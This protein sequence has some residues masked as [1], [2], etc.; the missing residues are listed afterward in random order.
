MNHY[1]RDICFLVAIVI[2]LGLGIYRVHQEL[3]EST[4]FNT[5]MSTPWNE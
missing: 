5:V 2:A 3:V 1:Y 4:E